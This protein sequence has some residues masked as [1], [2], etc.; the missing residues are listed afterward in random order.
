MLIKPLGH[1]CLYCKLGDSHLYTD[2]WLEESMLGEC[3]RFPDLGELSFN[4]PA[5]DY[6]FISHHHWDHVILETLVRFSRATQVFIPESQQLKTIFKRLGFKNLQI[7]KPW[8]EV[9]LPKGRLIATPSHVP[10]GEIGCYLEDDD[11]AI[12]NL[13][14]TVFSSSDIEQVNQ[15]SKNQLKICF[16]PYQSYDEMSALMRR[17]TRL[18]EVVMQKNSE[19]L[20]RLD[21]ELVVPFADG[22]YYPDSPYMNHKSFINNPFGFMDL[23]HQKKPGQKACISLPFD[24]F[25][26]S[27]GR[28]KIRRSI[29][30]EIEDL[31]DLYEEF[32]SFDA[33]YPLK[34]HPREVLELSEADV[35]SIKQ[36]FSQG[37]LQRFSPES[38]CILENIN[39]IWG[40]II[41]EM[42]SVVAVDFAKGESCLGG[43]ELLKDCN[44]TLE[45]SGHHL[46]ELVESRNLLAILMQ[47][48]QIILDG[49]SEV[50]AYKSLDAL[51]YG[52]FEDK[53]RLNPY[54]DFKLM[55]S[56]ATDASLRPI[57]ETR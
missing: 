19:N 35:E 15:I 38:L 21:V 32:R 27:S 16:A 20:A 43:M 45:I 46:A 18:S 10:F 30:L 40:L 39:M 44:A 2:P 37:Y 34:P 31:I 33:A 28:I 55:E 48:D 6:V 53:D 1:A 57:E 42:K 23:L 52:G 49:K 56:Q 17:N 50:L 4:L 13:A 51:W 47:S 5:P 8:Q 25:S 11:G 29:P 14:D 12:W 24:E 26:L 36:Y 3:R 9:Q 41:P 7:L 54:L 22:L